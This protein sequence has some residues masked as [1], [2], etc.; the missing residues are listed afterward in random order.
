[1]H[2]RWPLSP[3]LH[4]SAKAAFG[5][6]CDELIVSFYDYGDTCPLPKTGVHVVKFR[7]QIERFYLL[8]DGFDAECPSRLV[9]LRMHIAGQW[10]GV[11]YR[12][13]ARCQLCPGGVFLLA[14]VIS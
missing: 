8:Q 1:M 13:R 11:N 12:P 6:I 2:E 14:D 4:Y 7:M 10:D 9:S 3:E 5:G